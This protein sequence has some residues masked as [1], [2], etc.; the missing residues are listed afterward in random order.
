M[1][2]SAEDHAD[3]VASSAR[4]S[5]NTLDY[6]IKVCKMLGGRLRAIHV[7][8]GHFPHPRNP[9][10]V[11][12]RRELGQTYDV[13]IGARRLST[14]N[15]SALPVIARQW[16]DAAPKPHEIEGANLANARKIQAAVGVP[17]I[18]TGG[19]QT[20]SVIAD[21]IKRG[22]CDLVSIARPLIAN[23]DLVHIF[24]RGQ[25]KAEKPCTYCNKCL[26]NVIENP[27]GCY[28]VT[29]FDGDRERMVKEIMSVFDPPPFG[30]K[31]THA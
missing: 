26:V 28:D 24:A 7:R 27:L 5:G 14:Y 18:C 30:V 13:M 10:C 16:N 12:L 9:A 4:P 15:L 29:R 25:N 17:V 8:P 22:D 1:K 2:I 23:N 31:T 19:F 6:S 21:A 20:A 3:A 11:N